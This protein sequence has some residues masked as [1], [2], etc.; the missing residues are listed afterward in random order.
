MRLRG[1]DEVLGKLARIHFSPRKKVETT[2][3]H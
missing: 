1:N 3:F 2:I